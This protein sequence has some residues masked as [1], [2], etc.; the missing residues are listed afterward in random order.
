METVKVQVN[1]VLKVRTAQEIANEINELEAVKKCYFHFLATNL[2]SEYPEN[3]EQVEINFHLVKFYL[4][5]LYAELKAV[6]GIAPRVE[7]KP[8]KV[9]TVQHS[10]TEVKAIM[11][12]NKDK[13][14]SITE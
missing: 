7:A 5:E 14:F 3:V 2:H 4:T 12:F 13:R 9:T 6:K 8:F 11:A 1:K 10:L